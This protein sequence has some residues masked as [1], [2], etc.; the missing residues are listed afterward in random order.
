MSELF[1]HRRSDAH[2]RRRR[3]GIARWLLAGVLLAAVTTVVVLAYDMSAGGPEQTVAQPAPSASAAPVTT[4]LEDAA[5]VSGGRVALRYR[6]DA[7]GAD[8]AVVTLVVARPDGTTVRKPLQDATQ[9]VNVDHTWKGTMSLKAGSYRYYARATVDGRGQ[10]VAVPAKLVVRAAVFPSAGAVADAIAWLRGRSGTPGFAVVSGD[11]KVRGLR[12]DRRYASYSLSKAMILVAYLRG[13]NTVSAGARATL[14]RMIEH[15]DNAAADAIYAQVGGASALTRLAKTVGMERFSAGGGW[16]SA[17]VTPA[18]QARFFFA[19]EKYIPEKHRALARELLS[20]IT[21]RQRWGIVAAAG[22][23]GWKVYFKG[24][25]SGGNVHMVQA[26]RLA[27]GDKV[28]ALAV[29]TEG[30][31]NWTYG[32]GTLKGV[33]DVLLGRQPTGAYLTQVLE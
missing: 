1:A 9:A 23:L 11:G 29:M 19:M 12:V 26:A 18:D 30:N 24:G 14:E 21:P 31:P 17:R 3:H 33:T 5:M 20:G 4:A 2:R 28:F 16:I 8:T 25:W 27:K 32:F 7:A 13:H 22:P 6:V 15:S 10:R